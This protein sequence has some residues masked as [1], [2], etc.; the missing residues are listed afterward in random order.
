MFKA[1]AALLFSQCLHYGISAEVTPE[2]L[3]SAALSEFTDLSQV[4]K[5]PCS[6]IFVL[7]KLFSISRK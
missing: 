7:K 5:N 1:A 2:D 3:L 6:F 4:G